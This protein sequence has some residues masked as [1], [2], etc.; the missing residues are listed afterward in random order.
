MKSDGNFQ[1]TPDSSADAISRHEN[2]NRIF[3]DVI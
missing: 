3:L 2:K 1:A